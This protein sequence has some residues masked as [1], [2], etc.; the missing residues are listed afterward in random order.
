MDPLAVI[1]SDKS[2]R[3]VSGQFNYD[4]A[5]RGSCHMSNVQVVLINYVSL[6]SIN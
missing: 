6:S 3:K 5:I 2:L 1:S 4:K